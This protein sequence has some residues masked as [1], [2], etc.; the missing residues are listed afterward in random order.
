MRDSVVMLL[1]PAGSGNWE[2]AQFDQNVVN[3]SHKETGMDKYIYF[4]FLLFS[5]VKCLIKAVSST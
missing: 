3:S 4:C 1:V 2:K 5:S